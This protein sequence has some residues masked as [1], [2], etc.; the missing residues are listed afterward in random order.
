[1]ANEAQP[2]EPTRPNLI[3]GGRGLDLSGELKGSTSEELIQEAEDLFGQVWHYF[4]QIVVEGYTPRRCVL[5]YEN[6]DFDLCVERA[7]SHS[8]LLL[9]LRDIDALDALI[10]RQKPDPCIEH[11]HD[12]ELLDRAG[13]ERIKTQ[14]PTLLEELAKG[15]VVDVVDHLDHLHYEYFHPLLGDCFGSLWHGQYEA[16]VVDEDS[17][18]RQVASNRFEL[19]AEYMAADAFMATELSAP[20][21]MAVPL[22][23]TVKK[24]LVSGTTV[25]DV[26]LRL[27]L[28]VLHGISPQELV[29]LRQEEAESFERF[30]TALRAA[31]K[32]RIKAADA[33]SSEKVAEDIADD[34]LTPAIMDIK[35]RLQIASR[36]MRR[37]SVANLAVGVATVVTG[38]RAGIPILLPAGIGVGLGI[39]TVHYAKYIDTA[40]EVELS[41]MYFLWKLLQTA[42]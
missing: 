33:G 23:E 14:G 17:L 22:H 28:P 18:K 12:R 36:G 32:E 8:A 27:N 16:A 3:V 26:A 39:P 19:H 41:D 21:A 13:L 31:I 1:M 42:R 7:S 5:M 34:I 10:F 15:E 11:G 6:G 35:Q 37:K 20:L 4:D 29:R 38:L 30:R 40:S 9:Y 25:D 24:R 2:Q